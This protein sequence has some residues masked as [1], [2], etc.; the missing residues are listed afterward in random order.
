M[1]PSTN[2]AERC[3][4]ASWHARAVRTWT[5]WLRRIVAFAIASQAALLPGIYAFIVAELLTDPALARWALIPGLTVYGFVFASV[6]TL[7][8]DGPR[9]LVALVHRPAPGTIRATPG[10]R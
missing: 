4:A 1:W 9:Q 7:I 2:A 5:W 8:A 3:V 6:F 10:S